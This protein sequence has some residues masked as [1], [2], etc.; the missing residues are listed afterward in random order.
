MTEEVK[1]F[2]ENHGERDEEMINKLATGY[3]DDEQDK[4]ALAIA[5]AYWDKWNDE[6]EE[7][8]DAVMKEKYG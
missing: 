2:M 3:V 4:Q 7:E 8:I 6:V 1:A 5:N